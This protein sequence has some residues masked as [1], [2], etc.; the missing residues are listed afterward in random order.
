MP[1]DLANQNRQTPA[2]IV[3]TLVHAMLLLLAL[4]FVN[5]A[6]RGAAD[7]PG[8]EVGV[9]LKQATPDGALY[10]GSPAATSDATSDATTDQSTSEALPDTSKETGFD[11][12][13]PSPL[14]IG[15]QT[16]GGTAAGELSSG[17]APSKP[18]QLPGGGARTSVFGVEGE[19]RKFAYVFDRSASMAGP[20][21]A[22][23]KKQLIKS[24]E[25]LGGTHQFQIVFFNF[26][27]TSPD[28]TGG[29]NRIAFADDRNK[30]FAEGFISSVVADGG[31]NRVA[32]L[33][34]ALNLRPDVIFFLTDEENPMTTAELQQIAYRNR[35][36]GATICTIEFGLGP[37]H[38]KRNFLVEL[39]SLTGGQYGYVDT[40]RLGR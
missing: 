2:W 33:T 4:L 38:G 7:E 35:R 21:L 10:E 30:E 9:V 26:R 6:P 16:G 22:A 27:L 31:T 34:R 1:A 17:G 20:P 25:S 13:L 29:Q 37:E 15:P 32:A 19:G 11:Q 40:T 18:V 24:L 8:R 3:S 39:A 14:G 5:V 23:A 36:V 12:L 28:L